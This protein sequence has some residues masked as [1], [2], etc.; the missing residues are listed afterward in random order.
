MLTFQQG[1]VGVG[2]GSRDGLYWRRHARFL[3]KKI[4]GPRV[5]LDLG[6]SVMKCR[7]REESY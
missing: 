6:R 4:G 1:R 3:K 5:K 7:K 2:G